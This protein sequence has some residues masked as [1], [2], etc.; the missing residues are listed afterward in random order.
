MEPTGTSENPIIQ[1][2]QGIIGPRTPRDI[3]VNVKKTTDYPEISQAHLDVAKNFSS[4]KLAGPP[5]CDELIELVVHM[6]T[7]EEASLFRHVPAL[8]GSKTAKA[9]A[10]REH[11]AVQEVSNI[12]DNLSNRKKY[13][14]CRGEGLK[15]KYSLIPLFPGVMEQIM[16]RNSLDELTDWHKK[17][18]ALFDALY[19][20]GFFKDVRLE[21]EGDVLIVFVAERP[22]IA[23]IHIHGNDKIPTEQ[24]K[25]ALKD[26]GL[27]EG[28]VFDQSI[29]DEVN[30]ELKHQYYSLGKYGVKVTTSAN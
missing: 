25:S 4:V 24:L 29:L 22:A 6:F 19:K 2:N 28:R 10:A 21:R 26:M 15:A 3:S 7:E 16:F 30:Q 9:I 1:I 17:F 11:R 23:E 5:I 27:S 18:A 13:M 14:F 8:P 20:T 12:L